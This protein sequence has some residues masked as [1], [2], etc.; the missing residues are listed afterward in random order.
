[1]ETHVYLVLIGSDA[2]KTSP[3]GSGGHSPEK[4]GTEMCGLQDALFTSLLLFTSLPVDVQVTSQEHHLKENCDISPPNANIFLRRYDKF[5]LQNLKFD[6]NF[7]LKHE[8]FANVSS[9]APVF[10]M[11]IRSQAPSFTAIYPLTSP[12]LRK[13]EPQL[14]TRRKDECPP[15]VDSTMGFALCPTGVITWAP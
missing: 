11:Q 4:R 12:Q 1:M 6:P 5:Q 3:A 15:P 8:N 14:L 7:R 2:N 10:F 9:K 13:S